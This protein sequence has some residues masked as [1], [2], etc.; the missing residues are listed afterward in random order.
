MLV[1]AA[2]LNF[3]MVKSHIDLKTLGLEALAP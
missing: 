3:A 2:N 1:V